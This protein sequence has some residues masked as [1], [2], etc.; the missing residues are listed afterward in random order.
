MFLAQLRPGSPAPPAL[1]PPAARPD[2]GTDSSSDHALAISHER[3]LFVLCSTSCL[4]MFKVAA[5]PAAG[6][7]PVSA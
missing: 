7:P 5:A 2:C 4:S 1:A 3:S 6:R